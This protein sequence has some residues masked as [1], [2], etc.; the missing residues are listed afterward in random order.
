MYVDLFLWKQSERD[1]GF[2]GA[3]SMY[4]DLFLRELS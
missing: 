2:V 3:N 1:I 4:V